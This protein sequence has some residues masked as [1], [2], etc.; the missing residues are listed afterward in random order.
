MRFWAAKPDHAAIIARAFGLAPIFF[1]VLEQ[2]RVQWSR[3]AS[4]A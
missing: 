2:R 4:D 1:I 3:H